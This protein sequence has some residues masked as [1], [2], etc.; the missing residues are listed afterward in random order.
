MQ[1]LG[2]NFFERRVIGG[3]ADPLLVRYIVFRMLRC[4]IYVHKLCRSD[5]DRALHDHPWPF[6]SI[7]LK[8]SY[9]EV[10]DQTINGQMVY[11][12]H[13][14]GAILVRPA[15]WRHRFVLRSDRTSPTWTLVIVGRRQRPWGF[16]L[17]TGWCWWRKHNNALNICEDEVIHHGGRD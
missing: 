9:T 15:E 4:G 1:V 7:I 2:C 3:E 17:P 16:F 12:H 5:Y 13:S 10:H 14:R 8:G 6:I 11:Q